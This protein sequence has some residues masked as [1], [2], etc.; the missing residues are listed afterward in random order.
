M[1]QRIINL[2]DKGADY[3][4]IAKFYNTKFENINDEAIAF[5]FSPPQ[6]WAN[7]DDCGDFPCSG[8]SNTLIYFDSTTYTGAV[9]PSS[10]DKSF[11]IIPNNPSAVKNYDNC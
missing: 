2:N 10:T 3:H 7:L 6:A 5:L 4:P 9:K 1:N 8:P 11:S